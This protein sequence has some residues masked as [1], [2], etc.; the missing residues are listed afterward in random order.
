[1]STSAPPDAELADRISFL[2]FHRDE[3]RHEV[4]PSPPRPIYDEASKTWMVTDPFE[5]IE[6]LGE[7]GLVAVPVSFNGLAGRFNVNL[8]DVTRVSTHVPL[9]LEGTAHETARRR[10]TER[11]VSRRGAIRSWVEADL[12]G[13]FAPLGRPGKVEVMSEVV[14]PM[15]YGFLAAFVGVD[16]RR[17]PPIDLASLVFDGAITLRRRLAVFEQLRSLGEYLGAEIPDASQDEID[18]LRVTLMFGKDPLIASFGESVKWMVEHHPGMAFADMTYPDSLPQTGVPFV[19]RLATQR[20]S[21]GDVVFEPGDRLRLFVQGFGY[22][23]DLTKLHRYFGARSHVCPGRP[24]SIELWKFVSGILAGFSTRPSV[25]RY[26]VR[27]DNYIFTG[28]SLLE[29]DLAQ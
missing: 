11:V 27:R 5:A 25:A 1:M 20:I 17:A 13:Y 29:L 3:A 26:E 22:L 10:I 16:L 8:D 12:A 6:I 4:Y 23:E 21:R 9:Y 28:P 19:E 7:P 18:L 2:T 14:T 24:M 15:V